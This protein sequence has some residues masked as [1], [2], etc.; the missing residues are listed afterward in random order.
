M[1][2]TLTWQYTWDCINLESSPLMMVFTISFIYQK[3]EKPFVFQSCFKLMHVCGKNMC[4]W[5]FWI[6]CKVQAIELKILYH[7]LI[8]KQKLLI[9]IQWQ[10]R[11][12]TKFPAKERRYFYPSTLVFNYILINVTF[13]CQQITLVDIAVF[14]Q[15]YWKVLVGIL[16]RECYDGLVNNL[17]RELA[18]GTSLL[19][20]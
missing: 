9:T 11:N 15:T 4:I 8:L 5:S 10:W 19:R 7:V 14:F 17:K 18:M 13:F 12:L 1:I 16:A 20:K 3:E 2:R 6:Y